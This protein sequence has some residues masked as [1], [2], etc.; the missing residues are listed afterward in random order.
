MK[1][2]FTSLR[3]LVE[4]AKEHKCKLGKDFISDD[5]PVLRLIQYTCTNCQEKFK[6]GLTALIGIKDDQL[7]SVIL[8]NLKTAEGRQ[9]IAKDLNK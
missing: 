9:S 8:D 6:I 4:K 1:E 2:D 7:D 3:E 5:D